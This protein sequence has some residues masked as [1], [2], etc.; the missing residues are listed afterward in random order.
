MPTPNVLP[1]YDAMIRLFLA[2]MPNDKVPIQFIA[3]VLNIPIGTMRKVLVGCPLPNG[4]QLTRGGHRGL[5][6]F[7]TQSTYTSPLVR[8]EL[9][10]EIKKE[11]VWADYGITLR[12][13]LE[14]IIKEVEK[15]L[16][17]IKGLKGTGIQKEAIVK[18][19]DPKKYRVFW[20]PK[21][22][23]NG[24]WFYTVQQAIY[25]PKVTRSV[26]R[27]PVRKKEAEPIVHSIPPAPKPSIP[28]LDKY[29]LV[30]FIT[31]IQGLIASKDQYVFVIK[32]ME[33]KINREYPALISQK[34][35]EKAEAEREAE[36]LRGRLK[37]VTTLYEDQKVEIANL[38]R[39]PKFAGFIEKKK[40]GG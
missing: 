38:K 3:H 16:G 37:T 1:I 40:S 10:K 36:L 34:E 15:A 7:F 2:S 33:D 6:Y 27:Y 8:V 5:E 25:K 19:G 32:Q 31:D 20:F 22:I 21:D 29:S 30:H 35:R 24:E 11:S 4:V 18:N 12:P 9:V 28:Q 23:I 14:E 26:T 17:C 13:D 39:H